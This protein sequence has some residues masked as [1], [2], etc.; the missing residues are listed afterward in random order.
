[1]YGTLDRTKWKSGWREIG[2]SRVYYRSR[3]EANFARYLDLLKCNGVIKSW[4]HEPETFWFNVKRGCRS[5]LPDFRVEQLNGEF[6]FYEVKGWMDNKSKTK[7]HRMKIYHPDIKLI[8]VGDM[9]YRALEKEIADTIP[10]WE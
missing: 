3:W 1:M 10:E 7:I 5:Y 8:V 9:E 6:V 4:E 2:G